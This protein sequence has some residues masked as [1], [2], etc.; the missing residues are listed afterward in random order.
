MLAGNATGEGD[1]I[2]VAIPDDWST[3]CDD[4]LNFDG[5]DYLKTL[6]TPY[7]EYTC[8]ICSKHNRK[9]AERRSKAAPCAFSK[10]YTHAHCMDTGRRLH[11]HRPPGSPARDQ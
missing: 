7:C 10:E 4:A 11:V 2:D 6:E 9:E 1:C 5:C 8:G 3:T